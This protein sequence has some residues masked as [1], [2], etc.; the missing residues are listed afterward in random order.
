MNKLVALILLGVASAVSSKYVYNINPFI[1]SPNNY[2]DFKFALVAD[3][4][5]ST[6]YN[7]SSNNSESQGVEIT[8][9]VDLVFYFEFF[10]W[11]THTLTLSGV[12]LKIV[13]YT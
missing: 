7:G 2:L 10:Q 4:G 1:D 9:K 5:Y 13:P 8:S 12:P 3:S 11:Y 6:N